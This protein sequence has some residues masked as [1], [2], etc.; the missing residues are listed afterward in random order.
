MPADRKKILVLGARGRLAASLAHVWSSDH[1]VTALARPELDA[2]DPR[3]LERV[4]DS[5]DFDVLV[6]GTG[7][8]NVDRCESARAEAEAVNSMAPKIMAASASR[9]KARL[10]HFSTDYVFDGKKNEPLTEDDTPN[11]LGWYGV[12]K[13]LGERLVLDTDSHHLVIRVSWVFGPAKPSFADSIITRALESDHLEAIADKWSCLTS[14]MECAAWLA[15]FLH[16][17]LPGGL[18]HA[19]NAGRTSWHEFG[20]YALECAA[21]AG[22][23]VRTTSITP[24]TLASMRSFHAPRPIHT[25]MDTSK[26]VATTGIQPSPWR[27]A[28][29]AH[30]DHAPLPPAS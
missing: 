13:L 21:A 6:N 1:D 26:L 16:G 12:T 24:V 30:I 3:S 22:L 27:V 25:V 29:K 2:A 20:T 17:D 28:L 11:P 23:P 14:A 18:Y 8:T 4:L 19:C 7:L 10:I 5:S 9:R 15:P